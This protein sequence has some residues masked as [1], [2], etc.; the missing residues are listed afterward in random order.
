MY[1]A[2][3]LSFFLFLI[4]ALPLLAEENEGCVDV[5]FELLYFMPT[6][7][8]PYYVISSKDN[9]TADN[10]FPNGKRYNNR[11]SY[12]LGY[13]LD[14]SWSLCNCLNDLSV[15][16]TYFD[17]GHTSSISGPFLYDVIGF[18]GNGAEE[19]EDT[20]YNGKAK[21]REEFQY[22]AIDVAIS[23]IAIGSYLGG[24][25]ENLKLLAGIHYA[26]L[27]HVDKFRST[28][29]FVV[30]STNHT[31]DNHLKRTSHFWGIGPELGLEYD[32][33]LNSCFCSCL[34]GTFSL[35]ASGRASLLYSNIN[36]RFD[37]SSTKTVGAPVYLKN[38][39]QIRVIPQVD[40]RVGLDYSFCFCSLDSHLE[41]GYELILYSNAIDNIVG[42]DVAY[43]GHT[44]DQYSNFS[45]QGPYLVFSAAF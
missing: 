23:R 44:T 15:R 27:R 31:L 43:A 10:P 11:S 37:Y 25:L 21:M 39:N 38:K 22:G 35:V 2:A 34:P 40:A 1:K 3:L 28:G 9:K 13:R 14:G 41:L 29:T 20:F 30:T 4:N 26:Y 32:Y 5:G 36:G 7:D 6:S 33:K 16:L 45:L 19:P 12:H 42:F 18:P 17:G 8:Q 24:C